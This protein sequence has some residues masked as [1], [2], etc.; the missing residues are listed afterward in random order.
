M[1]PNDKI[2]KIIISYTHII[3]LFLSMLIYP[4]NFK[5]LYFVFTFLFQDKILFFFYFIFKL[6]IIVLVLPNIKMNPP[7]VYMCQD[8]ILTRTLLLRNFGTHL[9]CIKLNVCF[10]LTTLWMVG[11]FQPVFFSKKFLFGN[12]HS[13]LSCRA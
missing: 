5:I 12:P 2:K 6:Y 9:K 10:L 4:H 13:P 3:H 8:K 7:Q 1:K 11:T